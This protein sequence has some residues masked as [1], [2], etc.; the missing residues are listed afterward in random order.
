VTRAASFA[1]AVSCAVVVVAVAGGC[2]LLVSSGIRRELPEGA[3]QRGAGLLQAGEDVV[4]AW[5]GSIAQNGGLL[6]VL[7]DRRVILKDGDDV[8]SVALV[9][10]AS[11][12]VNED[13]GAVDVITA[14]GAAVS[15]PLRSSEER[16][17]FARLI[18]T[19]VQRAKREASRHPARPPAAP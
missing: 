4:A 14:G 18:Q 12:V 3:R 15:L 16:K 19:E 7:S 5:D 2:F 8:A 1:V 6:A 17:A 13:R 11:I 9:D 10:V